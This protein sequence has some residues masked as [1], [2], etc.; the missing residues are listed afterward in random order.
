MAVVN[1]PALKRK[2]KANKGYLFENEQNAGFKTDQEWIG[3]GLG[4]GAGGGEVNYGRQEW[5]TY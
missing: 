3:G 2:D 5:E 1:T 4:L